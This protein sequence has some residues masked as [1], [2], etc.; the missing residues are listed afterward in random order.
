MIQKPHMFSLRWGPHSKPCWQCVQQISARQRTLVLWITT[1]FHGSSVDS[2]LLLKMYSPNLWQSHISGFSSVSLISHFESP[3]QV[4]LLFT[5]LIKVSWLRSPAY[6]HF[7]VKR[8][9]YSKGADAESLELASLL[10][11]KHVYPFTWHGCE[12]VAGFL[13][14]SHLFPTPTFKSLLFLWPSHL[15]FS[16]HPKLGVL[17][18]NH[19]LFMIPH[20]LSHLTSNPSDR[21]CIQ[22]YLGI[23]MFT[24]WLSFHPLSSDYFKSS[25]LVTL[26]SSALLRWAE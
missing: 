19:E 26:H 24:V 9:L 11:A 20:F 12:Y 14:I 17:S 18:Q 23:F 4:S 21:A 1:H 7:D 8:H 22:I 25:M 3:L 6:S 2:F 15:R 16:K 10:R 5:L 13:L